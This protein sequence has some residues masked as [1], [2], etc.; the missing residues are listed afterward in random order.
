MALIR[1]KSAPLTKHGSI[2]KS[3]KF[4]PQNKNSDL[5][6]GWKGNF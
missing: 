2:G 3:G 4:L 1:K 6:V 5:K